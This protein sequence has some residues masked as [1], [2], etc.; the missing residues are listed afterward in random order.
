LCIRLVEDIG[1]ERRP[2]QRFTVA[3]IIDGDSVELTGGDR[4]RLLAIDTPE[5]GQP[6]YQE[7]KDYLD[8]LT[9]GQTAR[10]TFA[11]RR[12]D[13]YGRLLGFLYIGDSLLVN[14]LIL[15][16]GLG[17]LFLFKDNELE[18]PVIRE[19]L[20]AQRSAMQNKVGLWSIDRHPETHYLAG[21]NSL[22]FH[23]PGCRSAP[24]ADPSNYRT[25][26]EREEA[27]YIGLSPCRR[28]QP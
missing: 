27:L 21:Q 3:K 26:L 13:K 7:A 16:K 20:E 9:L 18:R 24:K 10:L 6:Y 4:L 8:S 2:E 15:E 22:R 5:K 19:L 11:D 17:H 14:K 28:C 25:F 23:R 12:R 1:Q